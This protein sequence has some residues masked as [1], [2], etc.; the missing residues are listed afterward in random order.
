MLKR[1]ELH[2]VRDHFSVHHMY[3]EYHPDV[4]TKRHEL[5]VSHYDGCAYI[6]IHAVHEYVPH[7]PH[8][9]S[10]W[11]LDIV[12]SFG[13]RSDFTNGKDAH[14]HVMVSLETLAN[15]AGE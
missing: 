1:K 12:F 4:K 10:K 8:K 13:K 14:I 2:A 9:K 6:I 5:E 7:E 15:V 11:L 3:G